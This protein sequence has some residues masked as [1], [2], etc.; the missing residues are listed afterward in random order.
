[1]DDAQFLKNLCNFDT[2]LFYNICSKT[3]CNGILIYRMG[4]HIPMKRFG[5]DGLDDESRYGSEG[6]TTKD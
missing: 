3:I 6:I 5:A 1:M 4:K 2:K